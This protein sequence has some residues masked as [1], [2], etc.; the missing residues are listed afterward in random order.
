MAN[1]I[2]GYSYNRNQ[3]KAG[4]LHFGV[5]NFHRAHLEYMTNKLLENETL[6]NW[7]IEEQEKILE[8]IASKDTKIITEGFRYLFL[9]FLCVRQETSDDAEEGQEGTHLEDELDARL[10]GKPSEEGGAKTTQAK[11]QSEENT[12]YHS[13]LVWH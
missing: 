3:V 5:G 1:Q 2:N 4:I 12:S 8:K 9:S 11:H 6:Q 7:G 13:H 10:V